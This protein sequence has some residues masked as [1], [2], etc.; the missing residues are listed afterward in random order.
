MMGFYPNMSNYISLALVTILFGATFFKKKIK[1]PYFFTFAALGIVCIISGPI[2]NGTSLTDT[3]FFFR[4]LLLLQYM[5]LVIIVNEPDD[6]IIRTVYNT[7]LILFIIQIPASIIKYFT[8]GILESY[9]GTMGLRQG[10]LTT[11]FSCVA[12]AFLVD[13]H[14]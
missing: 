13:F 8:V 2:L 10:S 11:V 4:Q 1:L 3:F 5:Y 9:I 7:V 6:D 14:S 12:I